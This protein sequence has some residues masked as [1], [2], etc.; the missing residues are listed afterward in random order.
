ML[1]PKSEI[2][3]ATERI[4][5]YLAPSPLIQSHYYSQKTGAEIFFKLECLHP[6]HS[7]KVR[8][9]FNALLNL[10][11]AQRARGIVTASGGNH[12]LALSL[13]CATLALPMTVYLPVKT[14]QIKVDAIQALG[15]EVILH[16]DAWDESNAEAHE[17]ARRAGKS[18]IHPFDHPDVMAGQG[19]LVQE[20]LSQMEPVDTILVS[21]GGGGLIAGILSAVQHFSPQTRVI[22]VETVGADCMSKSVAAGEIVELPAITSIAES[23][24]AKRTTQRPFDIIRQYVAELVTVPDAAAVSALVD[25]LREEKLLVEPATSC[26]LA[27]LSGGTI[28]VQPGERV[29]VIICGANVSLDKVAQWISSAS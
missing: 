22:G 24:G 4:A 11:E 27:A 6:T 26:C 29:A 18:Y 1:I 16:G 2:A 20:L 25:V 8:G 5:P 12:G 7:F 14:P 9:A 21:I 28:A 3:A 10:P 17:V 23:L 13:A 15:A 19:T